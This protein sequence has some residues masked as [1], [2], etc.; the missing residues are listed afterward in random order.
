MQGSTLHRKAKANDPCILAFL[1]KFVEIVIWLI[2]TYL[3]SLLEPVC[4]WVMIDSNG[5]I[6]TLLAIWF[7]GVCF[8]IPFCKDRLLLAWKLI[9][10]LVANIFITVEILL[11]EYRLEVIALI[12][13][14]IPGL[15]V[16][17]ENGDTPM[18]FA[19]R[20]AIPSQSHQRPD[21][22]SVYLER[23]CHTPLL[24]QHDSHTDYQVLFDLSRHL[25]HCRTTQS[26]PLVSILCSSSFFGI[27][28]HIL[29]RLSMC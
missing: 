29:R 5:L 21:L 1:S 20:A 17:F 4:A 18:L 6:Y 22:S 12:L 27:M 11:P 7:W 8:N 9:E 24:K 28:L 15:V 13:E 14:D 26:L 2:M 19:Q 25:Q 3:V 10:L 23:C 16:R